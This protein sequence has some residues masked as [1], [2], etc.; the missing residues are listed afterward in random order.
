MISRLISTQTLFLLGKKKQL[1]FT[2]QSWV[3][4]LLLLFALSWKSFTT[5]VTPSRPFYKSRLSE[6]ASIKAQ[7]ITSWNKVGGKEDAKGINTN[8]RSC[9]RMQLCRWTKQSKGKV[10]DCVFVRSGFHTRS[11][12]IQPANMADNF[13]FPHPTIFVASLPFTFFCFFYVFMIR[14]DK[15]VGYALEET[16]L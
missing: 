10:F 3:I 2:F 16:D 12:K 4:S 6:G 8:E 11:W 13:T 5:R 9:Q 1:F 7:S 14:L 15:A